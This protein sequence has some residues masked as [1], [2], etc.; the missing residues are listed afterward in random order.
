M[1]HKRAVIIT[2]VEDPGFFNHCTPV[3]QRRFIEQ[4]LKGSV[5]LQSKDA[6]NWFQGGN[7]SFTKDES[8]I[9][10]VNVT[11]DQHEFQEKFFKV[12]P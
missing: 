8:F 11:G 9:E 6:R 12:L 10:P 4:E 2:K 3:E 7:V 1:I 5:K